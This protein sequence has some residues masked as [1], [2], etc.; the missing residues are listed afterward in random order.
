MQ[1]RDEVASKKLTR[2]QKLFVAE[3]LK[4]WVMSEGKISD[5]TKAGAILRK[6]GLPQCAS[7]LEERRDLLKEAKAVPFEEIAARPNNSKFLVR[8]IANAKFLVRE[9][10]N[11]KQG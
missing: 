6:I 3:A 11:A 8:A 4:Y 1:S 2:K 10:A 5:F 9:I 7:F